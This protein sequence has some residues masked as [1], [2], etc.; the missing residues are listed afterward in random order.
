MLI[1][2][3]DII[4]EIYFQIQNVLNRGLQP[5]YLLMSEEVYTA[6][7][8]EICRENSLFPTESRFDFFDGL[9]VVHM[10]DIEI[11]YIEVRGINVY[12]I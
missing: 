3:E 7:R 11:N 1:N 10:K 12:A 6:M 9:E 4:K 5:Y 2:F 8:M